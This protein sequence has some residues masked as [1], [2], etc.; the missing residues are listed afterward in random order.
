MRAAV[1]DAARRNDHGLRVCAFEQ[2]AARLAGGFICPID[3][4]ALLAAVR[5]ALGATTL[6]ELDE[7]KALPG[8][9]HAAAE[10]LRKAWRAE[11]DLQARAA[12]HPR[13]GSLAALE[14]AVVESLPAGML[15]PGDI[16]A[17]AMARMR[18]AP[19][20][21]GP[22][23]EIRGLTELSPVWRPLLRR[24]AEVVSVTWTAGPREVPAWLDGFAVNVVRGPTH[25]PKI[26]IVSTATALHGVVEAVRWARE[27]LA[28]GRAKPQEIGIASTNTANYDDHVL[29][30]RADANLDIHFAHGIKAVTTRDGQVAAALADILVHGLS[31]NRARRLSLLSDGD[32]SPFASLPQGWTRILPE[33]APLRSIEKWRQFLSSV[34]AEAWPGGTDHSTELLRLLELLNRGT[35]AAQEAGEMFLSGRSLAIWRKALLQNPHSAI[36]AAIEEFRIDDSLDACVSIAWMPAE[37]LAVSPRKFVRLLGLSSRGWPRQVSEDRL[38]S[39]HIVPTAELDPLPVSAADRR[40]FRTILATT[41][42][43]VV[44]SRPRRDSEGRL[45]GRSPLLHD[46][47]E[48]T[49]LRRTRTPQ[50]AMSETDRMLARPAEFAQQLQ[51]QSAA[52]CWRDWSA[53]SITAHDGLVRSDHPVIRAVLAR[54]QSASSLRKLLRDP[55]GFVWKYGFGLRAPEIEEEPLVLDPPM[56]GNLVHGLLERAVRLIETRGGLSRADAAALQAALE[57]VRPALQ[58]EWEA[59]QAVP[60]AVIWR[61]TLSE[62]VSL[63]HAALSHPESSLDGQRSYAEV[64]FGSDDA[65]ASETVPWDPRSP[66]EVPGTGLRIGG[67]I[68]RL[69]LSADHGAARVR[70]YKTGKPP[71]KPVELDGGKE[72]QRCLYAFAV[73]ALLGQHVA[74]DASLLYPRSALLLRMKSPDETLGSLKNHLCAARDNLAAGRAVAGPDSADEYNDLAFALPANAP[75]NYCR[76]KETGIAALLGPATEVWEAP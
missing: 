8:M 1:L 61:R 58:R 56:F 49:Y 72:L 67:Y 57:E 28:S 23:V 35:A 11:I 54:T 21:F 42:A 15:R 24:L 63:A 52:A 9:A 12:D 16:V 47:G 45:L 71:K 60:P 19:A 29:A 75:N 18:F 48:E 27:L 13:I 66:V 34:P 39:D 38:L 73:K 37:A 33:D 64:K 17:A 43:E 55:L 30:L 40:D 2:L 36:D 62:A 41:E 69:D 6:G 59:R 46:R 44:L 3:T 32:R 74:V 20:I 10:T 68:D 25:D 26:S 22:N 53:S 5:E 31:Q 7:I 50:H 76:R 4:D 65:A 70:D 14:R 51:A